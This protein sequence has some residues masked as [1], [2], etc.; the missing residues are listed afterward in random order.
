MKAHSLRVALEGVMLLTQLHPYRRVHGSATLHVQC[1][2]LYRFV[3]T[4]AVAT[5]EVEVVVVEVNS[6]GRSEHLP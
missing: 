1:D 2:I 5:S 6:L 4:Q 3:N